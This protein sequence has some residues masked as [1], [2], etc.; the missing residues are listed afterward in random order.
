MINPAA[1]TELYTKHCRR[2]KILFYATRVVDGG[3][4]LSV[5]PEVHK[6]CPHVGSALVKVLPVPKST[7]LL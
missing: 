4:F 6:R 2:S 5:G 7:S 3:S 1:V